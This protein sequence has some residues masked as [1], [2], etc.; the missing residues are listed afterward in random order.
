MISTSGIP[1]SGNGAG[2]LTLAYSAQQYGLPLRRIT[3]NSAHAEAEDSKLRKDPALGGPCFEGTLRNASGLT[4]SRNR[5]F[6]IESRG[7][8]I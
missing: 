1:G 5:V 7:R 3:P 6:R 4:R 8:E 2:E